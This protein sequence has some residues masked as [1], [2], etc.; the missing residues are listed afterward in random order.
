MV[1]VGYGQSRVN[2]FLGVNATMLYKVLES[3]PTHCFCTGYH[4]CSI[5][6]AFN[7]FVVW[8]LYFLHRMNSI[9]GNQ[10]MIKK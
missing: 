4:G 6:D 7:F 9:T 5:I 3:M 10:G 2:Y 1:K 8:A